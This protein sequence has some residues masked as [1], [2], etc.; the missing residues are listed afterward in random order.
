MFSKLAKPS[1]VLS[2][3]LEV[4]LFSVPVAPAAQSG[5]NERCLNTHFDR[6]NIFINNVVHS[7]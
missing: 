7:L 5:Q 2:S 6:F 1:K 4:K 3:S